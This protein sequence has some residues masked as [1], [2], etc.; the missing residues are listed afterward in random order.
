[1]TAQGDD[2]TKKVDADGHPMC[3]ECQK[4]DARWKLYDLVYRAIDKANKSG[5]K[6]FAEELEAGIGDVMDTDCVDAEYMEDR[7]LV[8][9][10]HCG[11]IM[12]RD[13]NAAINIR[14]RF[15]AEVTL[16]TLGEVTP[17]GEKLPLKRKGRKTRAPLQACSLKQEPPCA[18]SMLGPTGPSG[19]SAG[20]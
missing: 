5:D 9:I 17:V 2:T 4:R 10:E 1:M 3:A 20:V 8:D 19:P 7:G 15:I 13:Q 12:D 14:S 11:M 18:A 6:K 16:R